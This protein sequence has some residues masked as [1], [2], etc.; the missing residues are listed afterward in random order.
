MPK[1]CFGGV[2]KWLVGSTCGSSAPSCGGVPLSSVA[3]RVTWIFQVATFDFSLEKRKIQVKF[4][5]TWGYKNWLDGT[6]GIEKSE[7]WL[8]LGLFVYFQIPRTDAEYS[9]S[10]M[11]F[12][13][14]GGSSGAS[15]NLAGL[16]TLDREFVIAMAKGLSV[17][18]TVNFKENE[19]GHREFLDR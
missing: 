17:R 8:P 6:I 16:Y 7:N 5:R 12:P 2:Q 13:Q 9:P 4:S 19:P 15:A 18:V 10:C 14:R 1:S 11:C 3:F